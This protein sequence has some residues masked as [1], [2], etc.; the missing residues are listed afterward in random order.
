MKSW[1]RRWSGSGGE[2][3]PPA[4]A[5]IIGEVMGCQVHDGNFQVSWT[6]REPA[7]LRIRW[8]VRF[9]FTPDVEVASGSAVMGD[10]VAPA[11]P[12]AGLLNEDIVL[13]VEAVGYTSYGPSAFRVDECS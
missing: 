6:G 11:F 13:W 9:Q 7:D 8:S 12:G 5:D 3:P 4:L 2:T 1:R 10:G